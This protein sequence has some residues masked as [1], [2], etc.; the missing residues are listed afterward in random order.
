MSEKVKS[1]IFE[2]A[3][4]KTHKCHAFY[5][6]CTIQPH[7]LKVQD[8][9]HLTLKFKVNSKQSEVD[10]ANILFYVKRYI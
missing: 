3:A 7:I 4:P 1:K 10:P 6:K 2:I 8:Q 5:I 9:R